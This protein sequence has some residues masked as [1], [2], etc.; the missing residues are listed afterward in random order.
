MESIFEKGGNT[1]VEKWKARKDKEIME[2]QRDFPNDDDDSSWVGDDGD[3]DGD[4]DDDG[5]N[6][7]D[8]DDDEDDDDDDSDDDDDDGSSWVGNRSVKGFPLTPP[9]HPWELT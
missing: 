4:D 8:D 2:S 5:D 7:G 6:D 1:W 9:V 3:D